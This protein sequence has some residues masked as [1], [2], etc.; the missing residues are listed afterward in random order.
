MANTIPKILKR[1]N[2]HNENIQAAN[3]KFA[4]QDE[5]IIDTQLDLSVATARLETVKLFAGKIETIK[6]GEEEVPISNKVAEIGVVTSDIKVEETTIGDE[7]TLTLSIPELVNNVAGIELSKN[8]KTGELTVTL[9]KENGGVLSTTTKD[10]DF[11][12]IVK[13]AYYDS[14][15]KKIVLELQS[16]NT[17]DVDLSQLVSGLVSTQQDD[18]PMTNIMVGDGGS[19]IKDSGR[20]IT[21]VLDDS[22]NIPTEGAVK[23]YTS[24][25]ASRYFKPYSTSLQDSGIYQSR[26]TAEFSE[27]LK[28][29]RPLRVTNSENQEVLVDWHLGYKTEG[30]QEYE[31]WTLISSTSISGMAYFISF[32]Y[33]PKEEEGGGDTPDIPDVPADP[34]G[35]IYTSNGTAIGYYNII[36]PDDDKT[37]T[38]Y[39]GNSGT[40]RPYDEFTIY[41]LSET[42]YGDGKGY[43]SAEE[44][45]HVVYVIPANT[46]HLGENSFRFT[47]N[48]SNADGTMIIEF[49]GTID[50][51]NSLISDADPDWITNG[52]SFDLNF[53]VRCTGGDEPVESDSIFVPRSN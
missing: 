33:A 7:K 30:E 40:G 53:T 38:I 22:G 4:G 14:E 21:T 26:Y 28:K 24:D 52:L 12:E 13:S 27:K 32:P 37:G 45:L 10:I 47:K 3:E 50:Q 35:F 42:S 34:I 36:L 41:L 16:G 49:A 6:I 51:W 23:D 15:N 43:L 9:K 29:L 11:E 18:L 46:T 5:T 39:E 1:G 25:K 17:K 2:T 20:G 8:D 19:S 44:D 48:S 31:N